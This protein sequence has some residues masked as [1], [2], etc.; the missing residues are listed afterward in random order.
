MAKEK[1]TRDIPLPSSND[2][3]GGPGDPKKI[4][5]RADSLMSQSRYKK[6]NAELLE[7]KAEN[8]ED[9]FP[10]R[11]KVEGREYMTPGKF[12]LK[13]KARVIKA[14]AALDSMRAEGLYNIAKKNEATAKRLKDYRKK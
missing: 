3:F 7:D 5:A 14:S 12:N 9:I 10:T 2:L 8:T 4:K 11:Y 6:N 1:M 13:K